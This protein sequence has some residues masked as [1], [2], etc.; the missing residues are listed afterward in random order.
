[1]AVFSAGVSQSWYFVFT[2]ICRV[3]YMQW[4]SVLGGSH[5]SA[6]RSPLA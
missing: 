6:S 1:M 2:E 4:A 5:S 3:M